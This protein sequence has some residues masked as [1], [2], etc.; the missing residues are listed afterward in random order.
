MQSSTKEFDK[1]AEMEPMLDFAI[2]DNALQITKSDCEAIK[3][4]IR[5]NYKVNPFDVKAED[6]G[7]GYALCDGDYP[8]FR[9]FP[10]LMVQ[11]KPI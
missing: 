1:S 7:Y 10:S 11:E 5:Q 4:K 2:L 8:R 6:M 9:K 3:N